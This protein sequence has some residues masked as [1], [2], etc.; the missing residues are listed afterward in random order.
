MI[1][2]SERDKRRCPR[3]VRYVCISLINSCM[4]VCALLL[5]L[6][7]CDMARKLDDENLVL[8]TAHR[9][10]LHKERH[11]AIKIGLGGALQDIKLFTE[12]GLNA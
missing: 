11:V 7:C 6:L 1:S 12:C 9:G 4:Y 8:R 5:C 2:L 10:E 3:Y